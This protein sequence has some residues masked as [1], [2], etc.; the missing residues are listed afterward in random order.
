MGR[1]KAKKEAKNIL[2]SQMGSQ[3]GSQIKVK[4]NKNNEPSE[5]LNSFSNRKSIFCVIINP[6][7]ILR[8]TANP[9]QLW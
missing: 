9:S 8:R 1:P 5:C 4:N 3:M 6:H 2:G 7:N